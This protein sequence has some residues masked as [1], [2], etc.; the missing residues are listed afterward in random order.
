MVFRLTTL[1]KVK[2]ITAIPVVNPVHATSE[3]EDFMEAFDDGVNFLN[4]K[5]KK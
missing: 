2:L 1:M 5:L 4:E 3:L